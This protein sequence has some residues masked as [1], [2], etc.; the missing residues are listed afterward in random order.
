MAARRWSRAPAPAETSARA[1]QALATQL[2]PPNSAAVTRASA[3]WRP[4]REAAAQL[5]GADDLGAVVVGD[6][7]EDPGVEVGEHLHR[8]FPSRSWRRRQIW[9]SIN[10][11]GPSASSP[12]ATSTVSP[13]GASASWAAV[14]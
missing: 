6:L 2:M 9:P 13:P 10:R 1:P 3:S 11:Y 12:P 7:L 8:S 4:R 14:P 5:E